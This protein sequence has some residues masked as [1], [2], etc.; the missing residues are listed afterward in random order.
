ML[1]RGESSFLP[2]SS[3]WMSKALDDADPEF[4]SLKSRAPRNEW[5]RKE[6]GSSERSPVL[7]VLCLWTQCTASCWGPRV[8]TLSRSPQMLTAS[9]ILGA[10][11]WQQKEPQESSHLS[12]LCSLYQ[13]AQTMEETLVVSQPWPEFRTWGRRE[14]QTSLRS[15]RDWSSSVPSPTSVCFWLGERRVLSHAEFY[16]GIH[17]TSVDRPCSCRERRHLT[18]CSWQQHGSSVPVA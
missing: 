6:S 13:D 8:G 11:W 2:Q 5:S 15:P 1:S 4:L 7:A 14:G 9:H 17:S 10:R 12:L 3:K 18:S 16:R